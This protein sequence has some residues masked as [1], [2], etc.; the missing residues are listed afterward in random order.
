VD[1]SK[2]KYPLN[3]LFENTPVFDVPDVISAENRPTWKKLKDTI[4]SPFK[5]INK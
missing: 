5:D 4:L 2:L 1:F 3:E